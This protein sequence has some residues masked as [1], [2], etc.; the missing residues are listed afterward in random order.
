MNPSSPAWASQ[1]ERTPA[2]KPLSII[3]LDFKGGTPEE[4]VKAIEKALGTTLNVIIPRPELDLE[5]PALKLKR[6]TIPEVF[7]ALRVVGRNINTGQERINYEFVS[8]GKSKDET[9]WV[10]VC[11]R[12][13]FS[14]P[15]QEL[16]ENTFCRFYNLKSILNT[17]EYAFEDIKSVL[18]TA[19]SGLGIKPMPQ[20]TFNKATALLV[21]IGS[22]QPLLLID[23]VVKQLSQNIGFTH[24]PIRTI[25][26]PGISQPTPV[27][28]PPVKSME[29]LPGAPKPN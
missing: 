27:L 7:D 19:W 26:Q 28:P 24:V 22:E 2:N 16:N 13:K 20:L 17:G 10:F 15:K 21:A 18:E 25:R 11:N 4:L 14:Q 1:L 29:S 6:V 9:I 3:D 8:S 12:S 23:E 5:L